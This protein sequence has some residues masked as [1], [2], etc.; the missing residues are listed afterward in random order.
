MCVATVYVNR[1]KYHTL[2]AKAG[3]GQAPA[4]QH[5]EAEAGG[6]SEF[7]SSRPKESPL[8]IKTLVIPAWEAGEN[9]LNE[10]AEVALGV[11]TPAWGD[12]VRLKKAEKSRH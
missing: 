4:M 3:I 2:N 1:N 8:K 12:R 10:E 5:W 6:L 7:R 9:H 11:P